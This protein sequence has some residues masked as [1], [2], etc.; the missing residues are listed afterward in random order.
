MH[1][2]ENSPAYERLNDLKKRYRSF[3][4]GVR[5]CDPDSPD[6][7]SIGRLLELKNMAT[8]IN[9]AM[10]LL[11]TLTFARQIADSFSLSEEENT[12][13][14]QSIENQK[15]NSSGF[16]IK[17]SIGEHH[18]LAII[19]CMKGIHD[20]GS[21]GA[22]QKNFILNDARKLCIKGEKIFNTTDFLKIIVLL[23]TEDQETGGITDSLPKEIAYDS[24]EEKNR[25]AEIKEFSYR[26][27][28][29]GITDKS[30][31]Y[32]IRMPGEEIDMKILYGDTGV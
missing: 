19:K 20:D 13:L 32:I 11:T 16:D 25:K 1:I 17:T 10:T 22:T 28:L 8:A 5:Q 21:F 2:P 15:T 3:I 7:Y 14:L 4:A 27:N 18:L 26:E 23:E 29:S 31:V 24:N 30:P 6:L 12:F 9:N